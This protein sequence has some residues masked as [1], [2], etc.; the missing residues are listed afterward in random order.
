MIDH[1]NFR[2]IVVF[3]RLLSRGAL[4][5]AVAGLVFA[6]VLMST[7]HAQRRVVVG[8][9]DRKV[10]AA[11]RAEIIDEVTEALNEVYIFPEKAAEME[12]LVRFKLK[13]GAYDDVT[14]LMAFS[15]LL[16]RDLRA[17]CKDRHLRVMPS[18]PRSE[19]EEQGPSPDEERAQRLA[20][21]R[22]RNFG[23]EK[24]ERLAGNIGYIDLRMFADAADGGD[25]AIAALNFLAHCD[26]LIVDLRQNGG[27][28]PSMI[29]LISSYL[30][31]EPQHLNSFYIR[32][33]DTTRQFWTHALVEG[34]RLSDV[35]VYVL[36]SRFT[37]SAAEEFTYNLKNMERATIIGE[38]TGGGAHP[39]EFRRFV[40]CGVE[41]SLPYGRAISPITKTNWEGTGIAPH[42]KVSAPEALDV[43]RLEAM[44]KLV[45]Q[46]TD[47]GK[48]KMIEWAMKTLEA[49][50]N[51]VSLSPGKLKP[52]VGVF[53]P[54][55]ITLEKGS[56]FYKRDN[57]PGYELVPMG[58][59]LFGL[60]G[61]EYF[62]IQ[63]VRDGS[64]KV[65]KLVGLYDNG[66]SDTNDRSGG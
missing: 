1:K 63:F 51:P 56:L 5:L 30:F 64:G 23:F 38:T 55:T 57:R 17:I 52:F 11:A 21:Q 29:Q 31:D 48:K 8:S 32:N 42:I 54:R 28:S 19:T 4:K 59:D 60:N 34:P 58:G 10:D 25:T 33:T 27:G 53:G 65:S 9:D 66:L 6:A 43:A 36:T 35:P 40:D 44:K 49:A 13:E 62:R 24:V 45:D 2:R 7:A 3:H 47:G 22:Y 37:F 14:S 12:E 50:R 15:E 39:V 18:A 61:L 41:M 20:E 26:A 46:V 16:T